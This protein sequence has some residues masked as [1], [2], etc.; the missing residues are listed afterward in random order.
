MCGALASDPVAVP[1]LIGL[2]IHELSVNTPAIPAIKARVRD[3]ALQECR[4][5]AQ[6]A[7]AAGDA[8]QVRALVA[9]RHGGVS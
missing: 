6:E 5:T 8:E 4:A 9:Q 7:L 1:I 3:L 2:G